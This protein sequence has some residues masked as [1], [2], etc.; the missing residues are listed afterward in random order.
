MLAKDLG[1][2][3]AF[4]FRPDGSILIARKH[5]SVKV[6]RD[7]KILEGPFIDI[8]GELSNYGDEW[9]GGRSLGT[10]VGSDH[11]YM[12]FAADDDGNVG[13][14]TRKGDMYPA[15]SAAIP[16]AVPNVTILVDGTIADNG[17]YTSPVVVHLEGDGFTVS[18]PSHSKLPW[19]RY[20]TNDSV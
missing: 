9:R 2:A 4:A 17:T 1:P 14:S 12:V 18:P 15:Q 19:P 3:T 10:G 11:Q 8:S 20:P 6:Y 16:G 13:T 5:G 7:G